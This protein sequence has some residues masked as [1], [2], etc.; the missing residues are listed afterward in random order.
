M[1]DSYKYL[2]I[3]ADAAG[4]SAVG[5]I[6]R[7]DKDGTIGILEKTEIISYGACGLPYAISENVKSFDDLIHF[8]GPTFGQKTKSDVLL[9]HEAISV[10]TEKKVVLVRT[11]NGEKEIGYEKLMLGTGA[12]AIRLPFIDY[13]SSRIFELKTVPDGRAIHEFI[14]REKPRRAAII[15]AGYI[16]L[17]AAESFRE[18]GL[19]V[20]IYEALDRPVPR[21]PESLSK[22]IVSQMQQHQIEFLSN[23]AV[24]SVKDT[25]KG[26]EIGTEAGNATFDLLL[27]AVGVK[28][29][30]GF[31]EGSGIEMQK[32]AIVVDQ[33]GAT[34]VAD[35]YA[36][37]DCAL[38]YHKILKKAVYYPLGHTANKQGRIAG[39][40]MSGDRIAFP[41]IV[42]TQV[43]KF[44]DRAY[45][46][47]GLSQKEA[48]EAGYDFEEASAMR[49]S[50][51]GY[52]PGSDKV[53]MT[54][55]LDRKDGTIL[56]AAMFGPLDSYGLIDA[57]S[58]LVN[59][60]ARADEVAWMDF[61]YAPPFAP[62]WNALISAAGKG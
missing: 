34:N 20:T 53:K 51:A 44:F 13:S 58:A 36:G 61:A 12:P 8:D 14:K 10:N 5:Q 33:Y 25:G 16:G 27:V 31:L 18:M 62:V 7:N 26:I 3:G 41:G 29:A 55:L 2:I 21:L 47:T 43:F 35:V 39:M 24:K 40:N 28:P 11:P 60:G 48:K 37:G 59:M 17:E 56:G 54:L 46:L 38:V 19:E 57:A 9:N 50:R 49:P 32:G 22:S 6:R 45:A 42:G 4:N 15:G 52:Y 23:T 30:T 1:N